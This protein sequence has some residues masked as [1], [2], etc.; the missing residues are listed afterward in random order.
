MEMH[1]SREL[2]VA[3]AEYSRLVRTPPPAILPKCLKDIDTGWEISEMIFIGVITA[4]GSVKPLSHP[5]N[6]LA[7][8]ETDQHRTLVI[9]A[10]V[11]VVDR[12]A[13]AER[14][15]PVMPMSVPPKEERN[16]AP[17]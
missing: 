14:R 8:M 9:T 7:L 12:S 11:T 4:T 17:I 15:M 10:Q 2:P 6:P 13:V 16:S 3:R 5:Q 1:Y